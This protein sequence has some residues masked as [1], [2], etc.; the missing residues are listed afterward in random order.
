MKF[1]VFVLLFISP[2]LATAQ[3]DTSAVLNALQ[4]LENGLVAKD[5]IAVEKHLDKQVAYGH[6]NGWV[7]S[8]ED[9]LKDLK[10]GYLVYQKISQLSVSIQ[11]KDKRN[12]VVKE[13]IAVEGNVNG[14][15]F[16]MNL[17]V[18]QWWKKVGGEWKLLMRQSA[19]I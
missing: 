7:Q 8:K 13:K 1:F 4:S 5:A 15:Q 12:A 6:S 9:V 17:F 19:K 10:S 3:Q 11:L 2:V 18:L 16:A 14:T